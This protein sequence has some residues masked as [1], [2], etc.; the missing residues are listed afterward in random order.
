MKENA[1]FTWVLRAGY[2]S[3]RELSLAIGSRRGR[4]LA[5]ALLYL[6]VEMKTRK[7]AAAA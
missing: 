3:R 7:E 5:G 4:M 2:A 1:I 6:K